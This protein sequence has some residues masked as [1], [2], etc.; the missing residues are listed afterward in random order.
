MSALGGDLNLA[1]IGTGGM[2]ANHALGLRAIPGVRIAACCDID[3]RRAGDFAA[4]FSI[5]KA[6]ADYT[7]LLEGE[8]LDGVSVVSVDSAHA[9]ISIAAL[10]RGVRVLCEKPMATTVAEAEAMLAAAEKSGLANMI[11]FSKRNSRGLAA[12]KALIE[13]GSLGRILHVDASYCQSWL[14]T[15]CWGDWATEPAWLWRLSVGHGSGGAL[16]DIGCH[17]YDMAQ[18]LAGDIEEISCLLRTFD[19]GIAGNRVGDYVFDANDSFCS[20]VAFKGGAIGT[21]QATRWAS[22][23]TNREYIGVYGDKGAVEIDYEK[24]D[25]RLRYCDDG[26]DQWNDIVAPPVPNLWERF[27]DAI[28]SGGKDE[29]DFANGLRIQ[30]YLEASFESARTR[31]P[32]KVL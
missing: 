5:P 4:R 6:Y 3:E 17:V 20:T 22:G 25:H 32:V 8:R 7:A 2:A 14:A 15:K 21:V 27:V 1:I 23:H 28:R 12:A 24:G 13:K 16:G 19:K 10:E 29:C 26:S 9:P 18:C 11:H 31:G 30:R